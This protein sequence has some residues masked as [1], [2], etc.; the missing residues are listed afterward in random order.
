M[1]LLARMLLLYTGFLPYSK[2]YLESKE[3][4]ISGNNVEF[5]P[6][7]NLKTG[8][9]LGFNNFKTT[10]QYTLMSNQF[11]DATNSVES[12]LG[13]IIGQIPKYDVLDL[14]FSYIFNNITLEL[15]INNVLDEYYF[16][17]RATG[18][19]GPGIIPSPSRNF[20]FLLEYKF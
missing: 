14:S 4:G 9:Q 12:D 17:N 6:K 15:S 20:S 10:L 16:T 1:F 7:S 19:P 13:G 2:K 8:L 5:I 3:N 11:T 18:Y